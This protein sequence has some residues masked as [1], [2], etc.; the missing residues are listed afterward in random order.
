MNI[1][2]NKTKRKEYR[3]KGI[4]EALGGSLSWLDWYQRKGK[5]VRVSD[6]VRS[7]P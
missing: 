7:D 4:G 1:K 3:E 2:I 5:I 6:S